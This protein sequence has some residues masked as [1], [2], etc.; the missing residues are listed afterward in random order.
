M[1]IGKKKIPKEVREKSR[2]NYHLVYDEIENNLKT[3]DDVVSIECD[4]VDEA[5]RCAASVRT[6]LRRHYDLTHSIYRDGTTVWVELM[7]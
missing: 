2:S 5:T 1:K 4:D 6:Y 7:R 3:F